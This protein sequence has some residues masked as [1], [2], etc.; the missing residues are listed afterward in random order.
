MEIFAARFVLPVAAPV[1]EDGAVAVQDGR[2][3]AAG[4]VAGVREAAGADAT[5]YD[6]G[7]VAILPGL[8]NAHTHLELAWA[9]DAELPRGDYVKWVEALVERREA[10]EPP[11]ARKAA[12]GALDALARRGTVA[13]GD[14]ANGV[15]TAGLLARSPLH[16][17]VF[18][19]IYDLG[20][21]RGEATLFA[22]ARRLDEI[23]ADP[24]VAQA[25]DRIRVALA[26]HSPHTTSAALLRALAG[27]SGA[28]S[29]PLSIHVA[30]SAEEVAFLRDGSGPL[31][32]LL[33]AR[34]AYGDDW[35]PP[36]RTPI[37]HLRRLGVLS[38]RTL[39]V[40]CVYLDRSDHRTLQSSG[41]TVVTCPRSNLALGVGRA[42]ISEL[43]REGVPVAL[44][45]DSLASVPD[46][47]LFAEMATLRTEHPRLS[48]AT[49]LRM[50]TLNGARA[51]GLGDRLG[52]I[53]AG[54]LAALVVVPLDP[55]DDPLT[56]VCAVPPVIYGLRDAARVLAG[57]P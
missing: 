5:T 3:V 51:L 32:A 6:L 41:A 25:R 38:P 52:S 20:A 49:V 31:G 12:E 18:H 34:G 9:V 47:D 35:A 13:L 27:R 42:P 55:G 53:E 46:L 26:P 1:V 45:T 19:E 48:A 44:G 43:L 23:A 57:A 56:A 54:K 33:R 24:H 15:F 7:S 30:E 22:A 17:V 36:G 16:A 39:V 50:A 10:G 28:T 21:D 14:V 11:G 8:V 2:I 37:E 40:H 29:D 4:P